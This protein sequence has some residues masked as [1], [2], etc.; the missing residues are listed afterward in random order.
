MFSHTCSLYRLSCF[1]QLPHLLTVQPHLLA[2]QPFLLAQLPHL[3]T[4][5]PHLLANSLSCSL[6][7]LICSLLSHTCSLNYPFSL[8]Y[9][10]T[11]SIPALSARCIALLLCIKPPMPLY[12]LLAYSFND[13]HLLLVI[14]NA[15]HSLRLA[16]ELLLKAVH[17]TASPA[18]LTSSTARCTLYSLLAFYFQYPTSPAC[19]SAGCTLYTVQPISLFFSISNISCLSFCWLYIVHCTAY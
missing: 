16:L 11:F 7:C 2:K 19:H 5:Q 18:C 17:C 12:S 8:L 13:Q 4:V 15:V 14:L 6:N 10:I 9:N 3:L 1:A